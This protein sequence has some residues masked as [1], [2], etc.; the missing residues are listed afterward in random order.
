MLAIVVLTLHRPPAVRS[1]LVFSALAAVAVWGV[2]RHLPEGEAAA[3]TRPARTQQ[4][5]SVALEGDHL[6][7][8]TLR[9]ALSTHIGDQL[10][11]GKLAHDRAAMKAALVAR[12]YLDAQVEPAQVL[13]DHG[14]AFVTFAVAP[15][16]SFTVRSV[17]VV[18]ATPRDAGVVTIA[19]GEIVLADRIA[20]AR[21]AL[22]DRLAAR[23][24][25]R[26]VSVRVVPDEA[27][28]SVD[29]ELVAR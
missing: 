13:F 25:P 20:H 29:I 8:A 17:K 22:A 10:D 24:K 6:P 26:A 23:G 1:L 18:G 5:E 16:P 9:A 3:E 14:A 15:G 21:D 11:R 4:V 28:A 7:M 2:V 12:G 19:Q 27:H